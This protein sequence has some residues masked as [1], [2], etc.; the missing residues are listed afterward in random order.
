MN[1]TLQGVVNIV[2]L[3]LFICLVLAALWAMTPKILY[4]EVGLSH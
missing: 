3:L 2:S 4:L 1:E